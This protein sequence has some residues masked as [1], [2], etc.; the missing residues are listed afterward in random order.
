MCFVFPADLGNVANINE[1][2]LLHA[3][4]VQCDKLSGGKIIIFTDILQR[5]HL[6]QNKQRSTG[7]TFMMSPDWNLCSSRR[8]AT[9]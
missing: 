9:E 1:S 3:L 8:A 4:V 7:L 2:Q 5:F 6:R